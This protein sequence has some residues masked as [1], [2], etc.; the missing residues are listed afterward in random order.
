MG[1]GNEGCCLTTGPAEGYFVCER[2]FGDDTLKALIRDNASQIEC[3]FC[4][5]RSRRRPIAAP[6]EDVVGAIN[7]AIDREYDSAADNLGWE[8]A[9][10]GYF[11]KHWDT[12]DLLRDEI[13]LD[14]PNDDGRLIGIIESCVGDDVWC[15]RNPYGL[16]E[17]ERLVYS[18]EQFC[19]FI[20]YERRYFFLHGGRGRRKGEYEE[21]IGPS[22]LLQVIGKTVRNC[23]LIKAIK[24]GSL[25]YRARHLKTGQNLA[26]PHDLGP[27]PKEKATRS[28][29][30]SPPGIVMFYGSND[31]R[32]AIAEIDDNPKVGIVVGTFRICRDTQVLDLTR[33]PHERAFFENGFGY[34]RYAVS[35]LHKFV[36]S[37]AKKVAPG[38]REYV[39]YVPTQVVTE[40]FRTIFR[41]RDSSLDGIYYPS[42]QRRGGK[43]LVL[44]ARQEH[45]V[46]NRRQF[47]RASGTEEIDKWWLTERQKEAWLRLVRVKIWR[48]P[49]RSKT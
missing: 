19:D 2:C 13:E 28:N 8:S 37:L 23:G 33:I 1:D 48:M 49:N 17:D 41:Y 25:V 42:T 20:K 34:D 15:E 36:G 16:R 40:W 4:G 38:G 24:K 32:T 46:L 10:G 44:F 5:R 47:R 30:M 7:C 22:E 31:P 3:H 29:R 14:L 35:F 11:G 27:P 21:I 26:K 43:S 9:E 6:L 18:W 45:L 39:D 12:Y